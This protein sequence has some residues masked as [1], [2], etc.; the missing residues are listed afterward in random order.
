MCFLI[1]NSFFDFKFQVLLCTNVER[2]TGF[3]F[4]DSLCVIHSI[5]SIHSISHFSILHTDD[6]ISNNAFILYST[7]G[8]K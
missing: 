2:Y 4:T 7:L 3:N 1:L 6:P 5:H 8:I